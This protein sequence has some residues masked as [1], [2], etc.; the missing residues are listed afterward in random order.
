M[1]NTEAAQRIISELKSQGCRFSL[2]D[3]GT[4]MS[5]F[6]YLK[7]LPVD[8][9][10]IDGSFVRQIVE[11]PVSRAMV[12]SINEIGHVMNLQTIAEFVEDEEIGRLLKAMGVD[13]LQG[14]G[15]AKPVPIEEYI[16]SLGEVCSADVG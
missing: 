1:S 15:I 11:D 3:F 12:S 5:S 9:L 6:A 13:Y 2:D 7:T 8:Y 16:E 14:Y 10:K 4:G